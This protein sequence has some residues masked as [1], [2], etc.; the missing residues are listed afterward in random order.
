MHDENLIKKIALEAKQK[1]GEKATPELVSKV[2]RRTLELLQKNDSFS[3]ILA[4]AGT[5]DKFCLVENLLKVSVCTVLESKTFCFSEKS[6]CNY[7]I[8]FSKSLAKPSEIVSQINQIQ[9]IEAYFFC[10]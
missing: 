4:V 3:G 5:K 2:V 1:L 8:D 10:L 6:V 9:G 7:K